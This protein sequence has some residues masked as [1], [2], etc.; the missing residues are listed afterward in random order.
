MRLGDENGRKR[1]AALTSVK[2][3]AGYEPVSSPDLTEGAANSGHIRL[4]AP[5]KPDGLPRIDQTD[6]ISEF[7]RVKTPS[8]YEYTS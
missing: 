8:V 2:A 4:L 5:C 7:T 3:R 1:R 6:L